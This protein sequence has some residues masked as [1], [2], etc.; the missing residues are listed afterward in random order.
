[1]KKFELEGFGQIGE[2]NLLLGVEATRGKPWGTLDVGESCE[3]QIRGDYQQVSRNRRD[4]PSIARKH[5]Q[6]MTK[7]TRVE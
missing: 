6:P 7:L 5:I 1:M 2:A 4:D 3:V